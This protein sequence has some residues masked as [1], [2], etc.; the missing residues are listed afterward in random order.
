[1]NKYAKVIW[2]AGDVQ[3]LR[4]DL[5]DTEAENFLERNQKHIQERL[6]ELG[7]DVI[8]TLIGMDK[9]LPE[10]PPEEEGE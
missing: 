1:M 8:E 3:T 4:P 6:V 7:W 9:H 2:T 10:K 5:S